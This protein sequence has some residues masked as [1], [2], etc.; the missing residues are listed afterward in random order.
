MRIYALFQIAVLIFA[1]PNVASAET[2]LA[3]EQLIHRYEL[4]ELAWSANGERLAVVV[5]EPVTEEG[6]AKNIWLYES[7]VDQ[8]RQ[9]TWAGTS[10]QHPRWSP[11]GMH[12]AYLSTRDDEKTELYVLSMSGGEPQPIAQGQGNI[13]DFQWSPDGRRIAY[14][15]AGPDPDEESSTANNKDDEVVVSESNRPVRL[16]LVDIGS[17]KNTCLTN[18][19]WRV[20]AFTWRPDGSSLVASA[21][22]SSVVELLTDRFFTIDVDSLNMHE[23]ARPDGPV[24]KLSISPDN[25]FL[26][27]IGSSDGGPIPY[28]MYL[29]PL[30]GGAVL[31]LTDQTTSRMI[32]DYHWADDGG[33]WILAAN[34]FGDYLAHVAIDGKIQEQPSLPGR[35]ISAF[36]VAGPTTAFVSESAVDPQELWIRDAL[37]V[38]QISQLNNESPTLVAPRLIRFSAE[39]GVEIEAALFEPVSTAKPK[40][41]WKTVLLI[42]GGPTGRWSNSINNWAQILV[43]EGFAVLAPNIRGSTGYGLDFVRSNRRDW[44]GADFRD[45]MAGV[46]F[47]IEQKVTDADRLAI[48]GWSYGGYMSAWAVTQTNRFKAAVVGAAMTDLAVEYGTETAEINAY[49]TWFL[50]TPYENLDDFVRMSPMTYIKNAQTPA[51]ILI[52]EDDDIDPIGQSRQFYRGLRRYGVDTELVVYPRERHNVAELHH[53]IDVLTR[54]VAWIETYVR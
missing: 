6:L 40:K 34:G 54:M 11:D 23:L 4:G 27:Y 52:G 16:R 9:I 33:L 18:G 51:L 3:P 41:G 47:L 37:G 5:T 12:L 50:G 53:R 2:T 15:S 19:T 31:N 42:H 49:D 29:Q 22:D 1:V 39:G 30:D 32:T 26:A 17:G 43:A 36:D 13:G 48:A 7:D 35:S 28:G 38:R 46:D 45:A 21:T 10:N 14:T 44:G 20:S 24:S 25:R 8:F